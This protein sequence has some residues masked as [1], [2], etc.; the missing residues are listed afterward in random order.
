MG[1]ARRRHLRAVQAGTPVRPKTPKPGRYR[2]AEGEHVTSQQP[3]GT[4]VLTPVLHLLDENGAVLVVD[5]A[6][7]PVPISLAGLPIALRRSPILSSGG[8]VVGQAGR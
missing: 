2:I 6:A 5:T 8:L 1:E 7:G 4:V 3:D